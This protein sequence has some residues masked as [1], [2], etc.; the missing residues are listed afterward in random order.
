[1]SATNQIRSFTESKIQNILKSTN[2]SAARATLAKLRRGIGHNPGELPEIWGE[3]L[4]GMPEELLG[5]GSEISCAEWAVYTSLTFFAFHQQGKDRKSQPMHCAGISLGTAAAR[6]IHKE[7]EDRERI[8]RRFYPA[9][10]ATDM[11]ELNHH[12]RGLVSLLRS[13]DIPLDYARL[14]SDLFLFQS[15]DFADSIRLRWGED[16]CR[17]QF[18]K[19]S[20]EKG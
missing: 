15:P 1:M 2:D 18:E 14:A 13:E 4:L 5:R 10:T 3:Y 8:S 7:D 12:L 16:F 9:A 6:L 20:E 11:I 17:I 19:D